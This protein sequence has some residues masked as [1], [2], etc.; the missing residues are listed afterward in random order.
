MEESLLGSQ[1]SRENFIKE[2]K[3]VLEN[4]DQGSYTIPAIGLYP[5]QWLWDSC[6]IAIGQ[7]N[8]NVERAQL[9][10]LSLLRGQWSNGM[11]PHIIFSSEASFKRDR[12]LW[13]SKINPYSPDTPSTSGMTQPP[14]VAEAVV[15]IGEKLSI[16]ERRSWYRMVYP[17]LVNY[18]QWLYQ[19]RDP[20]Q[21]GLVLQIHPWETG[22]DN[23]PPWMSELHDHLLPWWIRLIE[24]SHLQWVITFFRRDTHM[25]AVE[26]RF[27][28]IEGLALY[29]A[30]RRIRR[31]GY[32][33]NKILDHSLFAIE[34]LTFNCVFIRANEHLLRIAKSIKEE[35]PKELEENIERS[36]SAL[37]QLWDPYA[38]Q[39][40]SRDFITHRLIKVP[41]IA[42]FMP[43]YSGCVS[44]ERAK[45]IV[46]LLENHL[47]FGLPYPVP[48]VPANSSWFKPM[49]YWQGPTWVNTNW[50]I[51]DGLKR[52]GYHQL[53]QKLTDTTLELVSR[54]GFHEYFNPIN[55]HKAGADNFSWTASLTIDF[56]ANQQKK[57]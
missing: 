21:E 48:S 10:I 30:Q 7:R 29:D 42:A 3:A 6:F 13:R 19:D 38:S 14:M 24:K 23:T 49:N 56:L 9:E 51:I 18:H 43:L 36:R 26:E 39:Y 40:F 55:G 15:K 53:A 47:L 12:N 41:S 54:H 31:K 28:N 11:L 8:Y 2:A 25:V 20:H 44:E 45:A 52:Y 32:N 1:R 16:S 57:N 27:S 50:L 35:V 4:N 34:D 22:L 33:T 46:A 5:H 17:S 37:D